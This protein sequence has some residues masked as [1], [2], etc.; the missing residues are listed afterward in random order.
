MM[1]RLEGQPV[2]TADQIRAAERAA[3]DLGV[4][5]DTLM[6]RAGEASAA[7]IQRVAAGAEVVVL[8]GPGNNGGDG[9][10][11]AACLKAASVPVRVVAVGEPKSDTARWAR[12]RWDGPLG[13]LTDAEP[14]PI[15]V[16]ALFGTGL[17]RPMNGV[18]FGPL[19]D[20]ARY[21]IAVDI[22]SGLATDD[23]SILTEPPIF[24]LTLALGAAKPAHLLQPAARYCGGV[25]ILDIGLNANS[26]AHVI[27]QPHLSD[28]G[29]DAQKYTRG[30]VAVV[31]GAMAGASELASLAAMRS[32]AGYVMLLGGSSNDAGQGVPHALVRKPFDAETLKDDRIGAIVIGPGLG[33][34]CDARE[35]LEAAM[36]AA[37]PI[38]IDGDALHL[39]DPERIATLDGPVILTPHSG[40]FDALFGKGGGCKVVRAR[41]AAER[42]GAVVVFKGADTVIAHPDGRIRIATN[43]SHWLSTAG[44]GDVLAG[45]VAAMLASGLPLLEAA[46]AAVWVNG[47]AA[48][49]LGK[50]FIADDLAQALSAVRGGL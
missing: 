7:A 20:A 30:M 46:A 25:R 43:A 17:S 47:K 44:T 34:G 29:A 11:A 40:E 14:A 1:I 35:R 45:T 6:T 41:C 28:P 3:M 24:D 31:A 33:R 36:R 22:P 21:R 10:I 8:C 5:E 42:S 19:A 27:A 13:S 39:V 4:S 12:S 15:F 50:A 23:G 32:G 9:Y 38:V 26:N 37:R 49:R 2:L 48:R 18:S 16:D